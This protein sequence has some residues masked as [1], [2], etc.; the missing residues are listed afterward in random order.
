MLESHTHFASIDAIRVVA[1]KAGMGF[2]EARVWMNWFVQQNH[3]LM[4]ASQKGQLFSG[5]SGSA[6]GLFQS[7]QFRL[8]QRAMEFHEVG[9]KKALAMMGALQGTIFG[10]TS[11]PMF[12]TI[13]RHIVSDGDQR[14]RDIFSNTYELVPKSIGDMLLHG[15]GSSLIRTDMSSRAST[16]PRHL[17]L[18]PTSLEDIPAVSVLMQTG[19]FFGKIASA[20]GNGADMGQATL[21]A[22]S[23][24]PWNRPIRG[25][26]E[27][28]MGYT[29]TKRGHVNAVLGQGHYEDALFEHSQ[30]LRLLGGKPLAEATAL[31]TAYRMEM[32]RQADKDKRDSLAKAYRSHV[33]E[34]TQPDDA[35]FLAAY[36]KSG[37]TTEGYNQ[38]ATQQYRHATTDRLER[39]HKQI[40]NDPMSQQMLIQLGG[41]PTGQ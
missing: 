31:N 29:T 19:E 1:D 32:Y 18:V 17:T 11:L 23:H 20:A 40:K 3:G 39:L 36:T 35:G 13:N 24:N 16:T 8:M 41:S 9:D 28:A 22:L 21:D 34:G 33:L 10:A 25:M 4:T 7:Y 27:L 37:G 12:D 30:Y 5:I 14:H 6:I 26:A 2:D 15:V 38:W